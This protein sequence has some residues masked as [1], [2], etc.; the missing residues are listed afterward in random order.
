MIILNFLHLAPLAKWSVYQQQH[1]EFWIP[2]TL[3][4]G[5]Y[6]WLILCGLSVRHGA[7]VGHDS[8][9]PR[10]VGQCSSHFWG[11]SF[12]II[13]LLIS[14][15]TS[16]IRINTEPSYKQVKCT[17]RGWSWSQFLGSGTLCKCQQ[18]SGHPPRQPHRKWLWNTA[19]RLAL[20]INCA[21]YILAGLESVRTRLCNTSGGNA[22]F[23]MQTEGHVEP[24][25]INC[26]IVFGFVQ[27]K[28]FVGNICEVWKKNQWF[29]KIGLIINNI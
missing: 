1:T 8:H 4:T 26:P 13:S 2:W 12:N 21:Y 10:Q 27:S 17:L 14:H 19:D 5:M 25:K 6:A 28:T 7:S 22:F 11:F 20:L 24:Q 18:A 9:T 16:N 23:R 29:F 3:L 15:L